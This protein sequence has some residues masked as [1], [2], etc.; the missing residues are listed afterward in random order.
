MAQL[1]E[2]TTMQLMI[3]TGDE[4]HDRAIAPGTRIDQ[5]SICRL[6]GVMNGNQKPREHS[7]PVTAVL[8]PW[9][10]PAPFA[11][12]CLRALTPFVRVGAGSTNGVT[13]AG[14]TGCSAPP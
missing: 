1:I 4:G 14:E 5:G 7:Q 13:S 9:A 11:A 2:H 8:G 3:G 10:G 12:G 6:M